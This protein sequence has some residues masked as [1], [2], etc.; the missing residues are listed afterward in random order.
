MATSGAKTNSKLATYVRKQIDFLAGIKNQSEIAREAGF[1]KPNILSMIK[2][3]E[4]RV[5]LDR[6]PD[7]ARALRGDPAFMFRLALEE[8]WPDRE[9]AVR[10]VFGTIVSRNEA[11]LLIRIRA[12]T[13]D[14][15]PIL[16]YGL[17]LSLAD[18]IRYVTS[19][20]PS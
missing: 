20:T 6:I 9:G 16:V 3:G 13:N 19:R 4:V 17:N 18:I 10:A 11:E 2:T 7:L 5:P 12:L 1:E 15:D 8:Y 14:T